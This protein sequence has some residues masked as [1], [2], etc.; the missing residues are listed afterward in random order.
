ME[1][2]HEST[3]TCTCTLVC[4][5]FS[6]I[7]GLFL[8][9]FTYNILISLPP[10]SLPPSFLSSFF[11]S[12][13]GKGIVCGHADGSI[14]RYMF[15]EEGGDLTKVNSNTFKS[16][17][18]HKAHLHS[19]S[20]TCMRTLV[21]CEDV[22]LHIRHMLWIMCLWTLSDLLTPLLL[23]LLSL[24]PQGPVCKHSCPPYALAWGASTIM[25]AG[26]DRRVL[27][28]NYSGNYCFSLVS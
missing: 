23:L 20:I 26:C 7:L 2:I 12:P 11:H 22:S 15:E 6:E 4:V 18:I 27:V 10:P 24:P 5:C 1:Q 25:A 19:L 17:I 8:P 14:V 9:S 28:Y 16:I 3:C 21:L 13:S